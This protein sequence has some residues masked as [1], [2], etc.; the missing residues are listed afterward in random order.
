MWKQM[1]A[2]IIKEALVVWHD[3]KIRFT[4]LLSP[5]ILLLLFGY[6]ATLE[7]KNIS[8]A[9][10]NQDQG[11]YSHELIER[12]KGSPSFNHVYQMHS[13]ADIEKA[14][15]AQKVIMALQFQPNFSAQMAKG[16]EAHVQVILDGRRTNSSQIVQGYLTQIL[17]SYN[18]EIRQQDPPRRALN[19]V[20]VF[21]AWFNPN[22]DYINYT[23]PCLIALLSMILAL[24]ITALSVAREREMGTFDQ[25]LVSPL[26]PL[27]I[28]VGKTVPALFI[29]LV[30]SLLLLGVTFFIFRVSFIGSWIL[31]FASLMVFLMSVVGVGLF[32]S[33]L[34][35]TQQQAIL[36]VFVFMVPAIALSGYA[37]PIENMPDWL[38]PVCWLL[39][40]S[41]FM[42]IVKGI[43]IK[44]LSAMQVLLHLWPMLLIALFTSS[45]AVWMFR[46]RLA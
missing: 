7:V 20:A 25:L 42:I 31:F 46:R 32:I 1:L 8:I 12:I 13:T 38:Q 30:E 22:L 6:A 45:V 39:P 37:T 43:F 23:A 3:R 41:Y 11:W 4:L 36:G 10:Y 33:S 2:L 35:R 24:A 28:L 16:D 27:Q 14:I 18:E 21:R 29:S 40:T 26:S 44:N 9:I 15:D 5:I 34:A 17:Q 19:V